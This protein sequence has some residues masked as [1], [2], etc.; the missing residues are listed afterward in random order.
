MSHPGHNQ[1]YCQVYPPVDRRGENIFISVIHVR[2]SNIFCYIALFL[3]KDRMIFSKNFIVT[4]AYIRIFKILLK[5]RDIILI[6][7][8][9]SN[10]FI[11]RFYD[12]L[13][14][15]LPDTDFRNIFCHPRWQDLP[16]FPPLVSPP[17]GGYALGQ[18]VMWDW[19]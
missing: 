4:C 12:I 1:S 13:K 10:Q 3:T 16:L 5:I 17:D 2:K 14:Y 7:L 11:R 19:L 15:L 9:I 8:D 18:T 6:V